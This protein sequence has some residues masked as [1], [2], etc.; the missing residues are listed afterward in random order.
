MDITTTSGRTVVR[1]QRPMK[2]TFVNYGFRFI[3]I[4]QRR[5]LKA[6]VNWCFEAIQRQL[7]VTFVQMLRSGILGKLNTIANSRHPDCNV[8][9]SFIRTNRRLDDVIFFYDFAKDSQI[10]QTFLGCSG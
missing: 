6:R 10:L 5:D 7:A 9:K 8:A 1:H 4:N 3:P 2:K